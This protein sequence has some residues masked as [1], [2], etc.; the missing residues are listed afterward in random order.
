MNMTKLFK[1]LTKR[2]IGFIF[3]VLVLIFG[4]VWFEL[5]IPTYMQDITILVQTPGSDLSEILSVGGMMIAVTLGSLVLSILVAVLIANV[6]SNFGAKLRDII[7]KKVLSL[8]VEDIGG[9]SKPSLITRSTN[10]ITQIQDFLT[11]GLQMIIKSPIMAI[12][13]LYRISNTEWAWTLAT[14]VAGVTIIAIIIFAMYFVIPKFKIRQQLTDKLNLVTRENL[15]GINVV[16]AY[17]AEDYQLNKFGEVNSAFTSTNI[18]V[19]RI[20]STMNPAVM[21]IMNGLTLAIYWIGA[22]LIQ[23][24]MTGNELILFSD[25]IVFSTYA[26]QVISSIMML[27]IVFAIFPQ[28]QV[29]SER[30][31]DVLDT[32]STII[33]GTETEGIA[34]QL[35]EIE[36][37]NVSFGYKDAEENVLENIT[38]KANPGETVAIIGATGSGKSTLINLIPRFYDVTSGEVLVNGRN[39]KTYEK[40]S[41]TNTIGYVTQT[42]I[43]FS[44]D[45]EENIRYGDNGRGNISKQEI[46]KAAEIAQASDF[47]EGLEKQYQ[48]PV[49]QSGTNFSGGQKQR[50]SIA[51]A[52]ARDPKILLFDDSFSA[53]DFK[54]DS[55]LRRA[56]QKE[57]SDVTKVIVAQRVGTIKEVD[58]IIVLEDG[59]I[60]GIGTHQ[61]L[62]ETNEVYQ[63]IAHSQLSK[64]ELA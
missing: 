42:A 36:F 57:M 23:N 38:F 59:K 32:K 40:K 7:F 41:L 24:T 22:I 11:M 3:V 47:V 46:E 16:R 20:M 6:S 13:A 2:D 52:I 51:R 27:I 30:I 61:E 44:G 43:L 8:S 50:L 1:N 45:I 9:F 64:E 18:F 31:L 56:L 60:A 33:K 58:Q 29:S 10:D 4:Q 48:S 49:A 37:R 39:V 28:A 54:T 26:M 25:M 12:W 34:N 55:A 5:Q 19:N 62:L 53:L 63:E 14:I 21:L 35:G 17:N 15:T